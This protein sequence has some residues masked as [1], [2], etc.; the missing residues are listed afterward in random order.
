MISAGFYEVYAALG[1]AFE[2]ASAKAS[3]ISI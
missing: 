1:P 2:R 3:H